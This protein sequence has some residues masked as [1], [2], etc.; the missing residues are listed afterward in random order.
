MPSF[1]IVHS[2]VHACVAGLCWWVFQNMD[3]L[4]DAIADYRHLAI[5]ALLAGLALLF[6]TSD[7]LSNF[8]I[9]K[10][11][12]VSKALRRVL[13]G[14]GF[15]EGDWPLVVVDMEPE[16]K[17]EPALLYLGFL[18]IDFKKGQPFVHGD[19]W[20]VKG[21]LAHHFESMQSRYQDGL[22]QYWYEQGESQFT[23]D[24]RGYTEIYFFPKGDHA[25]R[26]AGTFLDTQHPHVRFY[27]HRRPYGWF[28]RRITTTE[29][30]LE[31]AGKL[32][33]TLEP[34]LLKLKDRKISVD[35]E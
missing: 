15:I 24:M 32:W 5:P 29:Q 10:I 27:A 14:R 8:I 26:H 13:S 35:F 22:L 16:G 23:P 6:R 28:E 9:E 12:G 25:K 33:S 20:T 11:P 2:A 31:A 7:S 17:S 34:K 19:D 1:R 3:Q 21:N 4:K 18:S 30:K